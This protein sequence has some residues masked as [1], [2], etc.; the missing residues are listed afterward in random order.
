MHKKSLHPQSIIP[1]E[2]KNKNLPKIVEV[3]LEND[4][5]NLSSYT[6]KMNFILTTNIFQ[7]ETDSFKVFQVLRFVESLNPLEFHLMTMRGT[8]FFLSP[9]T[10]KEVKKKLRFHLTLS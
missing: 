4:D 6:S 2:K 7:V 5:F 10:K 9:S 8:T 3:T 1:L